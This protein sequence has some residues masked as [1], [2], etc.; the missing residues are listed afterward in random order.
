MQTIIRNAIS[1]GLSQ[2]LVA[3]VL[4]SILLITSIIIFPTTKS[5]GVSQTKEV[6]VQAELLI[7]QMIATFIKQNQVNDVETLSGGH[8]IVGY[9]ICE[10]TLCPITH[11]ESF[12][13]LDVQKIRAQSVFSDDKTRFEVMRPFTTRYGSLGWVNLRIDTALMQDNVF[14]RVRETVGLIAIISLF[15]VIATILA[16]SQIVIAPIKKLK[17][18]MMRAKV[19]P[20]NPT[21]YLLKVNKKDEIA[22]LMGEFNNLLCDIDNYQSELNKAKLSSDVRWKFA[23]EG[24]GDGIWDWDTLSDEVFFSP[25]TLNMMGYKKSH[26]KTMKAWQRLIHFEDRQKSI[27]AL[28]AHLRLDTSDFSI[29]N[30]VLNKQGKWIW[31]LSRGVVITRAESGESLRVVGTHT[32]I[33]AQKENEEL[34]WSQSNIDPLTNLPN[35]RM[36]N[37]QLDKL[38]TNADENLGPVALFFIDLDGFKHINDTYGH[39][40]G[41]ALLVEASKRLT[42]VVG[43][44]YFASRIGGD[45]FTVILSGVN[46]KPTLDRV[47]HEILVCLSKPFK[48]LSNVFYISASIGITRYPEDATDAETL[49]MNADQAMY[50]SKDKGRNRYSYF[51]KQMRTSALNR[52]Q[53]ISEMRDALSEQQYEVFYQ[54]IIDFKTGLIV[55]AEALLR[56]NHP[57][58][59]LVSPA[60]I[61]EIAEDTGMIIEIGDW[62]F[63]QTVEQLAIWRTKIQPNLAIGINT[64]PAQ[65]RDGGIDADKWVEFIRAKGL[66]HSAIVIEITESL[67]L[68]SSPSIT[69]RLDTF[70]NSGMK[71]ALDDFGTGYSSLS[72]LKDIQS[73]YL[74]IDYSFVKDIAEGKRSMSLCNKI[75]DIAH[76]YNMKVIAEGVESS[77]QSSLLKQANAD[78][79]QGYLYSKPVNAKSFEQL[80]IEQKTV[81]EG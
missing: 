50:L 38:I 53:T 23:I 63:H 64:S 43:D 15:V 45:E 74:K 39:K 40:A 71:I 70:R 69:S 22:D 77:S 76:I 47:A 66:D 73:D 10:L 16:I 19:D 2:K 7:S 34:I 62:V 20:N 33:S 17:K 81:V 36:Y 12:S 49:T 27:D 42:T 28:D 26:L 29:E 4:A 25:Q 21:Q 80:L 65:Y 61:I 68:E 46:D 55:K 5:V 18:Q 57:E 14:S 9:E 6:E 78:F 30:R 54:P 79:G 1:A 51:S 44:K 56:W 72:Y 75:I 48:I 8:V 13:A 59:G 24:S 32:D 37:K 35:R 31:I 52:M 67:V 3:V 11:G 60:G 41:D 58:K